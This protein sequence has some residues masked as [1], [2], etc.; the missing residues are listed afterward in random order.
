MAARPSSAAPLAVLVVDDS[1]VSRYVLA[2]IVES[3]GHRC[4]VAAGGEMALAMLLNRPADVV[5]MDAVMPGLDG[6][7][8]ARAVRAL[9]AGQRPRAIIGV[10]AQTGARETAAFRAAG[11]DTVLAKPVALDH[12]VAALDAAMAEAS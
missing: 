11:A 2:S 4:R 5:L 1:A 12:L 9:P 10:S 6:F 8:T 3:L 7:A